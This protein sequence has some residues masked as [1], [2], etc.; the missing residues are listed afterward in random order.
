MKII[1]NILFGLGAAVFSLCALA[2]LASAV[3]KDDDIK[4][5]DTEKI[6]YNGN[7]SSEKSAEI[8]S[9][10]PAQ[11]K[12][13]RE[14]ILSHVAHAQN[15]ELEKYIGDFMADRIRYPELEREY[16]QRAMN[17][18]DLKLELL[19]MEFVQLNNT[20]AT[21]HTRQ[22]SSY[23]NDHDQKVVD[24]A[25]ISYRLLKSG[26]EWKIAFTERR[27]LVAEQ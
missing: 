26:D 21:V 15:R 22:L 25:I 16:A 18:K 10:F 19:A 7:E 8:E 12:E 1:R 14:F 20:S 27:R 5:D 4:P 2:P 24:D 13:V 23:T 9:K 6:A 11:A 17:L 3:D